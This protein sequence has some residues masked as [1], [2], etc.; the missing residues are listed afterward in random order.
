MP[1]TSSTQKDEDPRDRFRRLLEESEKADIE[2]TLPF[3]TGV[4]D[5]NPTPLEENQA[6]TSSV[7][8]QVEKDPPSKPSRDSIPID[9][10]STEVILTPVDSGETP[11]APQP[12]LET[13]IPPMLG[14]TPQIPPPAVDTRG[15]PLPRRVDVIDV[16]ATQVTSS[17]YSPRNIPKTTPKSTIDPSTL[18]S[19]WKKLG[20]KESNVGKWTGCV[21][22]MMILGLFGIVVVGIIS[23]SIMLFQYYKI[24]GAEDWPDVGE[25]YQRS[26]QF[27][28]TRIFDRNGNILYE[29]MDPSGGRR[30]YVQL[31]EISPY[32]VA[33]TLAT[34]DKDFYNHPGFDPLAIARA[35]WQNFRSGETVSGAS[36]ITQQLAKSLFLSAVERSQGTY[37][38]KVKEAILAAELTRL[39]SKD[40]I[41]ELY[42]NEINYGNLTYGIE[43]ASQTYFGNSAA[44]LS[45][46]QASFLAGLPQL[47]AIYD[48]YTNREATILRHRDVL[49]LMVQTSH[50]QGCIKVSNNPQPIC[51]GTE[52]A[53]E[54]A[55]IIEVYDFE[56]PDIKMRYPHWVNFVRGL[57][58]SQYDPQTIYRSGFDVYTTLD[59]GLQDSAQQL[60]QEQ[61]NS[62]ADR[63]VTNGALIVIR[64][65]TGEIMAMVGSADF[66][67]ESIDGQVN[68]AISPRQPGSSIK[69]VTYLAA[70]EKGWTPSTLIWDIYSEFP[71]SGNPNDPRDPYVPVNY[72]GAYHGPVTVRSAL[73][74]SYNIPAVKA[75]EFIGIY[76]DLATPDED[77]MIAMARKL[78]ITSFDRNDYGLSLTLG[79]GETTLLEM[80]G[81][82]AVIANGGRLIPPVAITRIEDHQGNLVF[83]YSPPGGEQV[84]RLEHAF[85]ISSILSDNQA[86][87]PAFGP[88]STL[89]LPFQA[90]AK[91]GTTNDFRDN[92]TIGY[93][94]DL[95]VGTW[96]GN[97]DY[98]PMEGTSGL[99]GAAPIWASF[100]ETA[101]QQMTGNNPT[102][103]IKPSGVIESV[104]CTISG[105]EPSQWCPS[106]RNEYFAADQP[107]VSK[108]YD[109]W[110]KAS[111]DTWTRLL[112][113]PE[114]SNYIQPENALNVTDR[115]AVKWIKETDQ[116]KSWAK[117]LGFDEPIFFT[118]ERVCTANDS[119]PLLAFTSL[120]DGQVITSN[121][122][123][124]Y[125]L[126]GATS[127]FYQYRLEFGLGGNP[128]EWELLDKSK[129]PINQPDD[130]YEWD[131][132]DFPP[133]RVTLRLYL[134]SIQNTFAEVRVSLDLQVPT[135]TPTE[136]PTSTPSPSSTWTLTPSITPSPT[137][138]PSPSPTDTVTFTPEAT[139]T[140]NPTFAE[141][142]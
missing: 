52:N 34:E 1:E 48:V 56:P 85:L 30:R 21:L 123:T 111:I 86:R 133:G 103:F 112:S 62:L 20:Y 39:Y 2:A 141:T 27:E 67:N 55:Q 113:S 35:F 10:R 15:M 121:P 42:L 77:G 66:N 43:A 24:V 138:T 109:L 132:S 82:Y 5:T 64:P 76:D 75:L 19:D 58:E 104:V 135:P 26:S 81:A 29:I 37:L 70:F 84:I 63:H 45:L 94:P 118:P 96:V 33:A 17:A 106:L 125:G 114:C 124:I 100:M 28:T 120:S 41:L 78:G 69:P 38:R 122:L 47:P 128:E 31:D 119:R 97:A 11:T 80:T 71:P 22:R 23:A 50:E 101:I 117:S 68:M 134:L 16:D 98:T 12:I 40:D 8:E 14:E 32:L 25:L 139:A 18:K 87:S 72:D 36:T 79:G 88:D 46:A 110:Q 107:P 131:I 137:M 73:A 6:F 108:G 136:T 99:T 57:L 130:L 59:P 13:P 3:E 129:L 60:V 49:A 54:A 115:W 127:D 53:A 51:I 83:Q 89:N 93:T 7:P 44:R 105:T 92:W 61:I 116:G 140:L 4:H 142:P 90:A 91:T 126:A 74:N 95:V 65:V 102:P 9:E